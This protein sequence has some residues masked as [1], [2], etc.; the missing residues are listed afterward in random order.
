MSKNTNPFLNIFSAIGRTRKISRNQM[1]LWMLI[2]V[3]IVVVL[4][5]KPTNL[6]LVIELSVK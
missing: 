3:G 2:I 6:E 5:Y 4:L 1:I